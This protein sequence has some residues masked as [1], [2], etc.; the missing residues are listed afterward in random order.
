[1]QNNPAR[2]AVTSILRWS[3]LKPRYQ[4]KRGFSLEQ[5]WALISPLISP[6]DR[7]VLDVGCNLGDFTARFAQMGFFAVGLDAVAQTVL[8]AM[9]RSSGIDNAVFGVSRLTPQ[10]ID[11][12]PAFD[13]TLCLSVAHNWH[14]DYGEDQ[15]WLMIEKL[16]TRS[17]TLVLET[18]SIRQKYGERPPGFVDN[19]EGTIK[20]YFV[21][22][23]G[24]AA[25]RAA[26]VSYLGKTACIGKEPYRFMFAVQEQLQRST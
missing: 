19:D 5:R 26:S 23:L 21:E 4:D 1:M 2:K 7:T 14:R 24:R 25:T 22:R 13:I 18:A 6:T 8:A 9:R 12:L 11:V 3:G 10:N 17:K 20:E 16:I 15:C